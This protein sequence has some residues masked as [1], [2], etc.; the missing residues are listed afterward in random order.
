MPWAKYVVKSFLMTSTLVACILRIV[1][2]R[3]CFID[4]KSSF[5]L[6]SVDEFNVHRKNG[7]FLL[8]NRQRESTRQQK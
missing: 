7:H 3:D 6:Q 1:N 4:K 8:K 2:A 5:S